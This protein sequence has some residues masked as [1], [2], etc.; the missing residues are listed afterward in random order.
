MTEGQEGFNASKAPSVTVKGKGNYKGTFTKPFV[1]KPVDLKTQAYAQNVQ[2]KYTGRDQK[3]ATTVTANL[4]GQ[5]V[6]LK[7][8]KDYE[9]EYAPAGYKEAG[10]YPTKQRSDP[11]GWAAL[12]MMTASP[13]MPSGSK[14]RAI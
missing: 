2:L 9:Y 11:R 6:T 13:C 12:H 5:T 1:I 7:A 4:G 3:P 8:G 14:R 10:Y